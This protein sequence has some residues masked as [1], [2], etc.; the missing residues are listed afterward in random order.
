MLSI[1][2]P[3]YNGEQFL[4]ETL[5]SIISQQFKNYELLIYNDASTDKTKDILE[6]Y[7]KKDQRITLYGGRKNILQ[8]NAMN[9]LINK[10]KYDYIALHDADDISLP[11]RLFQQMN[12]LI[13]NSDVGLLG[14]FAK[15]IDENS[16]FIRNISYPIEHRQITNTI[17]KQNCFAQSSVIFRKGVYNKIGKFNELF[18]PAQDYDMWTRM[19]QIT[20]AAN[21][22]LYLLQYREHKKSSSNILKNQAVI[23]SLFISCN[24]KYLKKGKDVL[25]TVKLKNIQENHLTQLFKLNKKKIEFEI[26]FSQLTSSYKQK[27]IIIFLKTF[28]NLYKLNSKNLISKILHYIKKTY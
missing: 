15:I 12:Y 23:K 7:Q 5:D 3:V 25:K 1:I 19:V 17:D 27:K 20:K 9:F 16:K 28:L 11:S 6:Y 8:P 2:M 13:K 26:K 10:T 18:N 24:Y 21:L 22:P 4:K 14:T